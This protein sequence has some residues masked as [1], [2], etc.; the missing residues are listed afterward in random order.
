MLTKR[1]PERD[2]GACGRS[3]AS[4]STSRRDSPM[5]SA[6]LPTGHCFDD[7]A[8]FLEQLASACPGEARQMRVYLVHGICIAS[9]PKVAH[10]QAMPAGHRY[11][12]GWV[13]LDDAVIDSGLWQGQRTYYR[14]RRAE[15]YADRQVE[16]YTRYTLREALRQ[17]L[18]HRTY[19]PWEKRY[20]ALC[21]C[22][23]PARS[24]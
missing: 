6:L 14:A 17:N 4:V 9:T 2:T 15:W 13:E 18:K 8:E 12:H 20:L 16:V 24:N 3:A 22:L 11:A 5:A 7:A 23:K 21:L 19:G 10:A 1:E